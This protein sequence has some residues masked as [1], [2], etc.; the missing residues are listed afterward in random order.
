MQIPFDDE[1]GCFTKRWDWD[2]SNNLIYEGRALASLN[3]AVTDAE[4]AIRKFTYDSSNRQTI[5]QW[6]D[7]NRMAD[8]VWNDRATLAYQ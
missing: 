4:W 6:A 3:S 2:A 1:A 5:M 8:N 7:G